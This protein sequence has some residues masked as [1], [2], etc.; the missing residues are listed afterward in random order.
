M[1]T[2]HLAGRSVVV[3]GA[4]GSIGSELCCQLVDQGAARLTLVSLTESG[5]YRIERKLRA[6]IGS[7]ATL[8]SPVLGNVGDRGLMDEVLVGADIVI[9]AA[10]H[11]HVPICEANPLVAIENNVGGTYTLAQAAA[12]ARV[13]Q[14]V[15]V[16]TDK[17]VHAASVMGATKRVAELVVRDRVAKLAPSTSFIVVRF[18]NVLGSD[19]SVVPLW[20]AQIEA[21]GP[22]TITDPDCERY[23]MTIPEACELVLGAIELKRPGGTF[24]FDMGKPRRLYDMAFEM[25]LAAPRPRVEIKVIGLRPGE[26]LTEDLHFGGEVLPTSHAK[27]LEVRESHPELD[28]GG[29]MVLL[30]AT[31]NRN[32]ERALRVLKAL[33]S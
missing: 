27:I 11:K 5:L 13:S 30:G 3:T 22:L 4:G 18:G 20:K 7:R 31:R 1:N 33:A 9:H 23:F 21:G 17:A 2:S 10:A 8:L 14:F 26:K 24:V 25:I 29:L 32:C 16:S 28:I 19:G 12:A 6:Y 15:L